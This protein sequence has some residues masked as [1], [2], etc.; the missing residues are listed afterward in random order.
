MPQRRRTLGRVSRGLVGDALSE[1]EK[2]TSPSP[3]RHRIASSALEAQ[4]YA[5]DGGGAAT[6]AGMRARARS[7]RDSAVKTG[8]TIVDA[9]FTIIRTS[10]ATQRLR[11]ARDLEDLADS[12]EGGDAP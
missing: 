11:I 6:V 10:E 3:N 7:I 2:A 12:L 5:R 4:S 9:P 8:V 1:Q